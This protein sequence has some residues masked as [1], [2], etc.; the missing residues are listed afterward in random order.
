MFN[1]CQPIT[2]CHVHHEVKKSNFKSD[3]EKPDYLRLPA[4]ELF[5]FTFELYVNIETR[6]IE[7]SLID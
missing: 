7:E 1:Y 6:K 4:N 3:A 5:T 2:I